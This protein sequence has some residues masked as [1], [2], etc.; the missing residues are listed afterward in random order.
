MAATSRPSSDPLGPS[1]HSRQVGRPMSSWRRHWLAYGTMWLAIASLFTAA[2]VVL[3]VVW[4]FLSSKEHFKQAAQVSSI[5]PPP[6]P[7]RQINKSV[8]DHVKLVLDMATLELGDRS[9]VARDLAATIEKGLTQR[10]ISISS[11]EDAPALILKYWE[12]K[13]PRVDIYLAAVDSRPPERI[14]SFESVRV[15][16][17]LTLRRGAEEIALGQGQRTFG[18]PQV[19]ITPSERSQ[20]LNRVRYA[21]Y[22]TTYNRLLEDLRDIEL[23]VRE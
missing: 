21:S 13:G 17:K 20:G 12:Q 9:I 1:Q 2:I 18:T 23:P 11:Q 10:N 8:G 14:D 5:A 7:V 6:V 22:Q 19:T 3:G 16:F 4:L 15:R